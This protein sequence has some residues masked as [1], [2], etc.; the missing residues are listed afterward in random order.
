M[1]LSKTAHPDADAYLQE[2]QRELDKRTYAASLSC[3]ITGHYL[4]DNF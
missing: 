3:N 1:T 4:A 2:F